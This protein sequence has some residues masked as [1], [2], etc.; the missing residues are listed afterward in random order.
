MEATDFARS[1]AVVAARYIGKME[2]PVGSNSDHGGPI[3]QAQAYCN[4]TPGHAYCA[5]ECSWWIHTAGQETGVTPQFKKSGSALGIVANNPDLV[6]AK[7]DF[8]SSCV[9]CLGINQDPDGVHGHAFLIVGLDDGTGQLQTIDPN[10][11]PHGAREGIGIFNL[12]V[13]NISDPLRTCYVRIA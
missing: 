13:R 4:L 9:P 11:N 10:S 7:E 1:V 3:D 5:S 2:D 6:I 8:N 12:D